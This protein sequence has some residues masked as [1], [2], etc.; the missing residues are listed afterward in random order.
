ML[1]RCLLRH[2]I[3]GPLVTV[4]VIWAIF[5]PLRI[6]NR[7]I[8][9]QVRYIVAAIRDRFQHFEKLLVLQQ[10]DGIAF[11]AK[12]ILQKPPF[13]KIGLLFQTVYGNAVIDD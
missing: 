6:L 2:T 3:A 8:F 4:G 7:D 12:Q 5:R 13:E 11:A 10:S 9:Q 1:F